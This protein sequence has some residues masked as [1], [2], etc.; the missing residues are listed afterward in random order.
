MSTDNKP[1]MTTPFPPQPVSSIDWDNVGFKV[2]DGMAPSLSSPI[3]HK[4]T[5]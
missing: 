2:R 4:N 5:H 1:N 3:L